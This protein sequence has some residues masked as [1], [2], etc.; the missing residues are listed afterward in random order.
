M[1][2]HGIIFI[3]KVVLTQKSGQLRLKAKK[4]STMHLDKCKITL[5]NKNL[6]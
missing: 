2:V 4:S 5:T 1:H 3:I 6:K